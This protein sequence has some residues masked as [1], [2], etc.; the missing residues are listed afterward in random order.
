[1][2]DEL[3]RT[4]IGELLESSRPEL[5]PALEARAVAAVESARARPAR[6]R[7]RLVAV[8]TAGVV[9]L[10][11]L[12]FVP[13][14]LGQMKGALD[15]AL[16][17]ATN[18]RTVHITTWW[19]NPPI[20]CSSSDGSWPLPGKGPATSEEWL[21]EE[22]FGRA[23]YRQ[24]GKLGHVDLSVG[25]RETDYWNTG[26]EPASAG[27]FFNPC[28]LHSADMP[29]RSTLE[30]RFNWLRQLADFYQKPAPEVQ[31][32][33][34][35]EASLWGGQVVVIEAQV[36][37]TGDNSFVFGGGYAKGDTVLVRAELDPA[38]NTLFSVREYKVSGS[39][40]EL[41]YEATYEWNG[42]IPENLRHFDLP[43]GTK[44]R[45]GTWWE[46]RVGKAIAQEATR[47]W[48]V[49]L[50]AID[51]NRH[52]D[53]LLSLSRVETPENQMTLLYN[54]A[55]PIK[56]E[57]LGSNG[58]QYEQQN[59][60]T[61]YNARHAGYWTTTL[62]PESENSMPQAIT[63]TIRPYPEDPS[64]DQSVTFQNVPLPS[65]QDADDVAAGTWQITQ[66]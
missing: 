45:R 30:Q 6:P 31:F 13:I 65:R 32:R 15:R 50:H 43:A 27:Q 49:T 33:E 37:I 21:A 54:T 1:M 25:P 17:S 5:T 64:A 7:R 66:Q 19:R 47:D 38:K 57:A 2:S 52:G 22:G 42:E 51:I 14:P 40:R 41:T 29:G 28:L 18:A 53:I 46:T 63:L 8:A 48:Q 60:Y 56:V 35:R 3:M 55:V 61:C 59:C 34:Y 39:D 36:T 23:E 11:G 9:V 44:V 10:V 4:E 20:V 16:A 24:E 26:D 62:K 58:E 12:G